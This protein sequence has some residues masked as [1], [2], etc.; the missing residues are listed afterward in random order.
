VTAPDRNIHWRCFHCGAAFTK[1]Q[2]AH[3]RAHFGRAEDADPV[4]LIRTAGEDA[5]LAALRKAED[6]LA[7][8]RSEDQEILRALWA[9][10]SDHRQALVRAEEEGYERGLRDARQEAVSP[11]QG[12][13]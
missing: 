12:C 6:E 10:Q 7:G 1:A 4:C 9:M 2:A 3:A 13:S 5:L 8:Y 11:S